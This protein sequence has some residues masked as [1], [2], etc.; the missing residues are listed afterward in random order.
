[1][2][3][4]LQTLLG[5][6][7]QINHL[8]LHTDAPNHETVVAI[9]RE[10]V[11]ACR[12]EVCS[13]HFRDHVPI[14]SV[15]VTGDGRERRPDRLPPADCPLIEGLT[16]PEPLS[17]TCPACHSE[18]GQA[19]ACVPLGVR[20]DLMGIM[21][22]R[23]PSSQPFTRE[24]IDVAASV[25]SRV[26]AAIR[27]K[28]LVAR[29]TEYNVELEARV[30]R[31]TRE[32]ADLN[33]ELIRQKDAAEAASQAKT[34][35]LANMSHEIRTPM[36]GIL[37]M[38]EVLAGTALSSEQR[39]YLDTVIRCAQSLLDLLNDVLDLSKVEA[40]HVEMECIPFDPRQV[41]E[42]VGAVL[43]PRAAERGLELVCRVAASMPKQVFGDPARVRQIL[44]NLATNA[45]KFTRRGEVLIVAGADPEDD[46]V[47]QL[48][49]EVRD[50][51][52][53]IPEDKLQH[54]F[55]K[56]TQLDGS[57]SRRHGGTGL[58]LAICKQLVEL[59]DGTIDVESR[60]GVGS[61]FH[62]SFP[63]QCTAESEQDIAA[64]SSA[65]RDQTIFVVDDHASSRAAIAG[66]LRDLGAV[67]LTA[68]SGRAALEHLDSKRPDAILIDTAMSDLDGYET[69]RR[70]RAT[71]FGS[72]VPI[73]LLAAGPRSRN[74][75]RARD[76]QITGFVQ[77]PVRRTALIGALTRALADAPRTPEPPP[78]PAPPCLNPGTRVLVVEDNAINLEFMSLLLRRAGCDVTT[79]ASGEEAIDRCVTQPF[80]IVLMDVQM[81]GKDGFDTT[82]ALRSHPPTANMPI[83]A[84]TAHAMRG[85]E[86]RCLAL[87]MDGYVAKPIDPATLYDA[88]DL[89]LRKRR[90]LRLNGR[91]RDT[92]RPPVDLDRLAE[93]TDWT[94]AIEHVDRFLLRAH[95]LA[96]EASRAITQG[97]LDATRKL[98]HQIRGGAIHMPGLIQVATDVMQTAHTGDE[99]ATKQVVRRMVAEVERARTYYQMQRDRKG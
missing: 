24:E 65:L 20:G 81:P 60:E 88:M 98:A 40:G 61:T 12:A 32:L 96:A 43:G 55:E 99:Q 4:S 59:M 56:F 58:G 31:R 90:D 84:V 70:I 39:G 45:I 15:E 77:K 92:E 91:G 1:V 3:D 97:D 27:R 16:G 35:F 30:E 37:G 7:I 68:P 86:E 18:G 44:T 71:P 21:L 38:A 54:L 2:D 13:F 72:T 82:M 75:R 29:L 74:G 48:W 17:T 79:A 33:A 80:D 8:T 53:G 26:G 19:R 22:L 42:S 46:G 57:T 73:I 47:S 64:A 69:A 6:L 66:T 93:D 10:L 67:V 83:V 51:G 52:I 41:V 11:C 9:A 49:F 89:A 85:D 95:E 36:N 94:F 28:A 62:F 14:E 34:Q 78:R 76:L 23:R 5:A 63:V 25:G 87:G 50:S